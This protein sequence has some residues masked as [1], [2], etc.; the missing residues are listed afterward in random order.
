[1][2]EHIRKHQLELQSLQREIAETALHS[3]HLKVRSIHIAFLPLKTL[4]FPYKLA[5]NFS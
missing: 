5:S 2:Q 1:M 4:P 3:A